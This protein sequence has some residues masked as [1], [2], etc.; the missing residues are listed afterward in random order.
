MASKSIRVVAAVIQRDGKYLI[1]QRR[2]DASLPLLWEFPGGRVEEGED[3][4]KALERE[5]AER[6]GATVEVGKP[7]AFRTHD[8]EGYSVELVLYEAT[9]VRADS[10][11]AKRV[12]EYRWVAADEFG[13]YPFPP[14]DRGT[15]DDFQLFVGAGKAKK[16]PSA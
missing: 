12:K 5:F 2:E 11:E 7:V 4:K 15:M 8:Y 14:A 9:L 16:P 3:D 13:Q 10:L 6:L 1:T